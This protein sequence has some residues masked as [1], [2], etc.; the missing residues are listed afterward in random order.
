MVFIIRGFRQSLSDS[1]YFD[2]WE[3]QYW[4]F[5]R[6]IAN[7]YRELPAHLTTKEVFA[8]SAEQVYF[9]S[10]EAVAIFQ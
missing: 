2:P 7:W 5:H 3:S 10:S 8:R 4:D 1:G 9:L 6:R